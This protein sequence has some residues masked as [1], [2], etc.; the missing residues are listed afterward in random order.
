MDQ[1]FRRRRVILQQLPLPQLDTV[2]AVWGF[3]REG[4]SLA[5]TQG[6]EV[7]RLVQGVAVDGFDQGPAHPNV[8]EWRQTERPGPAVPAQASAG[9]HLDVGVFLCLPDL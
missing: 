9:P 7:H 4:V 1:L 8:I 5:G 2:D 6:V 3:W